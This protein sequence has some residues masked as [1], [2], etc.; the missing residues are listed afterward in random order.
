MSFVNKLLVLFGIKPKPFEEQLNNE[1]MALKDMQL[2]SLQ[3]AVTF[4][5]IPPIMILS[6]TERIKDIILTAFKNGSLRKDD[7]TVKYV[8]NNIEKQENLIRLSGNAYVNDISIYSSQV[9]ASVSEIIK[10][11]QLLR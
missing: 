9:G 7:S 5:Y 2:K 4:D 6:H 11:L 8:L 3:P 1:I 10:E